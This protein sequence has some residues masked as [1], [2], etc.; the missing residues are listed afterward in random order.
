M[1]ESD[2]QGDML[3]R[4]AAEQSPAEEPSNT[5]TPP[6]A[7]Q[8]VAE[9]PPAPPAPEQPA[10]GPGQQPYQQ[11]PPPPAQQPYPQQGPPQ[12]GPPP[13]YQQAPQ[14]PPPGQ[15]GY[16]QYPPQQYPPQQPPYPPAPQ[17]YPQQQ[18]PEQQQYPPAQQPYP[19]QQGYPPPPPPQQ[20]QQPPQYGQTP[21]VEPPPYAVPQY[22]PAE[23]YPQQPPYPPAPQQ[24]YPPQQY[25]EQQ[26]YQQPYA[27][28]QYQ[29]QPPPYHQ[30][31]PG[32]Q[33]YQQGPPPAPH[34]GW[35]PPPTPQ[36]DQLGTPMAESDSVFRRFRRFASEAAYLVGAS[37]RIQRDVDNIAMIRRPIAI[38][39]RVGVLSPVT[40]GGTSTV[41][42]LL[43]M[44]LATQRS[45][46]VVA[47]DAD[48]G[49]AEL[50]RR[51][52]LTIGA[53][54]IERVSLVRSEGN[55]EAVRR[56]LAEAQS[57][58]AR[59]VGL[60]VVDCPGSMYDEI[61]MEMASS[62]HC[63]VLVVP[64]VQHVA[65][66][67]LQQLDQLTPDGQNVL[68]TR[69]VVV[70]TMVQR[71]EPSTVDWLLEEFRQ[72]GLEPLVLPYDAHIAQSWPV[73]AEQVQDETRRAVLDLSARV[74]QTV[75]GAT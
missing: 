26:Q 14:Y 49:G 75:T 3:R 60:A 65:N 63:V 53:G 1:T 9:V 31:H 44:M 22:P 21:P 24:Q 7:D 59:D 74:V 71:A 18:Y 10:P 57:Q 38:M 36:S 46:R 62:A 15:P 25:P 61:S 72:R 17:Q 8:P 39:R 2:W 12:Q 37:G 67:C 33:Q 40:N 16:E 56:S 13:Q 11:Q 54:P 42:A 5:D 20:Y 64:S 41:S 50:S 66:Y 4:M 28:P 55:A 47:I 51:L 73:H 29:Q 32:Q 45:D 69:G 30:Q 48:P 6:P 52:E 23:Q 27:D 58:G 43:A 70:I 19:P 68:L 34:T 35:G